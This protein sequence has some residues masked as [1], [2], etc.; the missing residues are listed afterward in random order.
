MVH[1]DTEDISVILNK[2]AHY[3][4]DITVIISNM[5]ADK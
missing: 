2:M 1:Y 3:N 4:N 5:I